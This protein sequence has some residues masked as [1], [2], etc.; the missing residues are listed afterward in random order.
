LSTIDLGGAQEVIQQRPSFWESLSLMPQNWKAREY[1][2]IAEKLTSSGA[3]KKLI[4][5]KLTGLGSSQ[6]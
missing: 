2:R 3:E 1:L 5:K 6:G 4:K